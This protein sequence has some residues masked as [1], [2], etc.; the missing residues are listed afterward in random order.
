VQAFY[1]LMLDDHDCVSID[2]CGVET[3]LLADV[4]A[5]EDAGQASD[6]AEADLSPCLPVLDRA[7]AQALVAAS[8]KGLR[9]LT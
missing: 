5:A 1:H 3:A 7:G 8:I 6:L 2:R 9:S 4:L